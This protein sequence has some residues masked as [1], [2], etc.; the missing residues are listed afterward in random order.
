MLRARVTAP[1]PGGVPLAASVLLLLRLLAVVLGLQ[2]GGIGHAAAD[3]IESMS[4]SAEEHEQCPADGACDDC[5]PGCPSCHCANRVPS[6]AANGQPLP[7]AVE[8]PPLD[9][10]LGL[11]ANRAPPG[12][13]PSS[14]YRPPRT[15][16]RAV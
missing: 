1:K 9:A 13:E 10:W 4:S 6:V 11:A 16:F 8:P 3:L 15:P 14:V 5:P 2:L 7:F 12:P